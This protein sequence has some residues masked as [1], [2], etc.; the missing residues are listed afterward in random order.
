MPPGHLLHRI[1]SIQGLGYGSV[2]EHVR[3]EGRKQGGREG[4]NR[5]REGGRGN[6]QVR[7]ER[8]ESLRG[9]S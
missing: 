6:Y 7:K 3:Q 4:R 1:R 5:G 2:A 8:R 9:A